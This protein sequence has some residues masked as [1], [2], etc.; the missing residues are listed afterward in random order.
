VEVRASPRVHAESSSV[1]R[2]GAA[3]RLAAGNIDFLIFMTT[4]ALNDRK[5]LFSRAYVRAV[6][7]VAGYMANAPELDRDTFDVAGLE[8]LMATIAAGETP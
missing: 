7:S 2:N 1:A 5:D 8:G 3:G 6:A 4:M